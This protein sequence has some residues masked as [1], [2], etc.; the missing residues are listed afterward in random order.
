M[1]EVYRYDFETKQ[2]ILRELEEESNASLEDYEDPPT[3]KEEEDASD[4]DDLREETQQ[5]NQRIRLTPITPIRPLPPV[6]ATQAV[7]IENTPDKPPGDGPPDREPPRNDRPVAEP[8]RAPAEG[9]AIMGSLPQIFTG[10]RTKATE[11]IEEVK[12][13]IRL[14]QDVPG[15]NSSIKKAALTLTLIKGPEVAGWVRNMGHWIDQ[16][17][18][19]IDNI[20]F[21]WEQFLSECARQFH[22][23]QQEDRARI[24]LENLRMTFPDI[25]GYISQFEDLARQAGYTK[26][27][28][29]TTQLF[30]S[31]L[32]K[33]TLEGV[34]RPPFV[35]GYQAIKERAIESTR[36]TQLVH[37]IIGQPTEA[38]QS[39]TQTATET[40]NNIACFHCNQE[41]H[42]VRNCPTR[43]T[44]VHL[45]DIREDVSI[46]PISPIEDIR[47]RL[48][49][50]TAAQQSQ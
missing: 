23:S 49:S 36:S 10:D 30:L 42:V 2:C 11:F 29:E 32:D 7:Q 17:N 27:N 4:N 40:H 13:Y 16:L 1:Q 12:G 24:K 37:S 47:T 14:N 21:V 39:K 34:L 48:A 41:G 50:L 9:P 35:H 38:V 5:V 33:S 25:D 18:P 45:I 28:P 44:Q 15:F 20:P 22:D 19:T 31:G 26:G 8:M 43:R 46:T 3:A 6:T